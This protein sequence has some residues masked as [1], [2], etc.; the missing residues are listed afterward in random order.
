[1]RVHWFLKQRGTG[2]RGA[3]GALDDARGG[4][5]VV[6]HVGARLVL[7]EEAVFLAERLQGFGRYA[8]DQKVFAFQP[9]RDDRADADDA[10]G[11]YHASRRDANLRA[12]VREFAYLDRERALSVVRPEGRVAP[13]DDRAPPYRDAVGE[14]NLV[15]GCDD[16]A[17]AQVEA[18]VCRVD[19]DGVGD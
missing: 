17:V 9:P 8:R 16:R 5:Q 14:V 1:E 10:A 19:D 3:R 12:D 18:R 11:W 6:R 13:A 2:D 7:D 4:S 15:P